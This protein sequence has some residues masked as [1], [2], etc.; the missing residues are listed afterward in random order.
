MHRHGSGVFRRYHV[1]NNPIN[2]VDP[3]GENFETLI[4]T[5][6]ALGAFVLL[7]Q[8]AKFVEGADKIIKRELASQEERREQFEKVR[9]SEDFKKT[10]TLACEIAIQVLFGQ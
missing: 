10:L 4:A 6:V 3:K 7:A 9:T 2:Y 8:I 1:R 5:L